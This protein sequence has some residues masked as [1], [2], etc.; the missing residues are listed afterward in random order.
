VGGGFVTCGSRY[1][2]LLALLTAIRQNVNFFG[3][4]LRYF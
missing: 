3:V 1:S 2:E 4:L